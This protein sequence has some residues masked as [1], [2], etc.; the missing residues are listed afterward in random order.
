M[1]A[2][3]TGTPVGDPIEARAIANVLAA[4]RP[5]GEPLLV[6]SVKA[7]IGHLEPA[8]GVAGLLKAVLVLEQRMVPPNLH[9][10]EPNPRLPLDRVSVPTALAPLPTLPEGRTPL[11]GVNSFGFGGANVHALLTAAPAAADESREQSADN[12]PYLFPFSARSPG[13]LT[14]YAAAYAKFIDDARCDAEFARTVRRLCARQNAS[15]AAPRTRRRFARRSARATAR[16]RARPGASHQCRAEDRVRFQRPGSA[17]V[18]DGTRTFRARKNRP[19]ILGTLRRHLPRARRPE[20][21]RRTSR[22][23]S[24]VAPQSHRHRPARALRAARRPRGIVA[25]VGHRA[26]RRRRSQRR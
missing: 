1:E 18:G 9:F 14:E 8:S 17:V 15:P 16:R 23:R 13:A 4:G 19:R 7:N 5:P 11:V 25:R 26:R 22:G 3:G 2:H 21:A 20:P 24:V 12:G 6:G 10:E